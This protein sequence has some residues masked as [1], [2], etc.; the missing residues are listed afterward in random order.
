MRGGDAG[1]PEDGYCG[2]GENTGAPAELTDRQ[3]WMLPP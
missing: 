3:H 2:D 1:D